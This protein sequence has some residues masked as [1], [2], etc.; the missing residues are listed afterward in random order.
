MNIVLIDTTFI[1]TST[2]WYRMVLF[3]KPNGT[4]HGYDI[5]V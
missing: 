2:I 3:S 4:V 5:S 1:I